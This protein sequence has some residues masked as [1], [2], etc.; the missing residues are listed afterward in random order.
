MNTP[1]KTNRR[2]IPVSAALDRS[3]ARYVIA[4]T[5]IAAAL[6]S[7]ARADFIGP[8]A[9]GNWTFQNNGGSTN[10][11]LQTFGLPGFVQIEGGH[12]FS[13]TAGTTDFTIA[14]V[15]SGQLT[16]SWTYF[17]SDSIPTDGGNFLLNGVPTLLA[18]N[19]IMS[20]SG[21]FSIFLNQGD[22]FG[23]E[24]FT[25]DNAGAP[26]FLKISNF[27]GPVGNAV[28]EAGGTLGL[29]ALGVAGLEIFRRRSNR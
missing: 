5:S 14:A 4:G 17:S 22:V 10:G 3:L 7:L 16:F 21:N 12:S 19:S 28:P 15:A 23:F 11:V 6:P 29:L 18:V 8:Y 24:V 25:L 9:V 20:S 13:N 27:D 2:K 1:R 26:G